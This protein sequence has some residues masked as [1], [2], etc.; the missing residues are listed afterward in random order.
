MITR[1]EADGVRRNELPE[2]RIVVARAVVVE[3]R[4]GVVFAGCVSERLAQ[5][6]GEENG[7]Y[8]A[9]RLLERIRSIFNKAIDWGWGA[10]I[11]RWGLRS[12]KRRAVIVFYSRTNSPASL[13]PSKTSITRPAGFLYDLASNRG[14]EIQ[15]ACDPLASPSSAAARLFA[16]QRPRVVFRNVTL[17]CIPISPDTIRDVYVGENPV[18]YGKGWDAADAVVEGWSVTD[19]ATDLLRVLK[20]QY[21]LL[22]DDPQCFPRHPNKVSSEL[23]RVRPL[24]GSRDVSLKFERRGPRG[25]RTIVLE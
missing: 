25:V 19:T 12:S 3:T 14:A 2:G 10:L 18:T 7:I 21:P 8:Q 6:A 9:Y 5:S 17:R 15:H 23:R 22:A 11:R 13:R 20:T 24:L 16:Q 1:C 4:F